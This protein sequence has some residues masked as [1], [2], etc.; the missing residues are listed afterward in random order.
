MNANGQKHVVAKS[1]HE[2]LNNEKQISKRETWAR[3][4]YLYPQYTL[5]EAS[6][7]PVRDL[8]LLL[9]IAEMI[10]AERNYELVQIVAAPHTKKGKGVKDLTDHFRK[11]MKK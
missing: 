9:K 3:V 4:C 2:A 11:L 5:A 7:L 8:R 6:K 10:E 1:V